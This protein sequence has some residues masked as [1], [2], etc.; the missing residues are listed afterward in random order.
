MKRIMVCL[1]SYNKQAA[2][3]RVIPINSDF[4][5]SSYFTMPPSAW[6]KAE[7]I[8]KNNKNPTSW[9]LSKI[10]AQL[11]QHATENNIKKIL[12]SA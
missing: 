2:D 1:S 8:L 5:S 6:H 10:I 11:H 4:K 12:G 7:A 3:T 9:N